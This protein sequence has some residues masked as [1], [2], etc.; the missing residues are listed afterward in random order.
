MIRFFTNCQKFANDRSLDPHG[1][2]RHEW[3]LV[4]QT[5]SAGNAIWAAPDPIPPLLVELTRWIA[6]TG[7]PSRDLPEEF[8]KWNT[9]FERFRRWATADSFCRAF[10]ALSADTGFAHEIAKVRRHG[11]GASGIHGPA[12]GRSR[13]ELAT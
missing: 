13:G 12:I 10:K 3:V 4:I 11:H 2:D 9:V 7:C 6:R 1:I 8:G 5:A